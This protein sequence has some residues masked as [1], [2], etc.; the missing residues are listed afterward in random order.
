MNW[1]EG[2]GIGSDWPGGQEG[3]D[4]DVKVG[5]EGCASTGVVQGCVGMG[6]WTDGK[7]IKECTRIGMP[8]QEECVSLANCLQ[9]PSACWFR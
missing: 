4:W 3:V 2:W 8:S 9:L 6:L 5:M 7:W 1:G